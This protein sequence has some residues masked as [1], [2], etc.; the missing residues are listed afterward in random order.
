MANTYSQIYIQ[1]VF[2]VK[3]RH[4][5]LQNPWRKEVFK[6]ISGIIEGK[7]QKSIIVN[8]VADHVHVFIGLKPTMAISDLLRDLKNN[9]SKF[10]NE[11]QFLQ[12]KFEWQAGFGAF[13]YSQSQIEEVY[14]YIL[15]QENIIKQ[16]PLKKSIWLFW[17]SLKLN[18]IQNTCLI[19]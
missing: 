8:G 13:S 17:K 4:N 11:Q 3:G 9:S 18:M 10:I 1:A 12:S 5:L 7:G 14:K 6:F 15:N 19:G 16:K 2:A